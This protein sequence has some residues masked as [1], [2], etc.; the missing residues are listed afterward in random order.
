MTQIFNAEAQTGQDL[1]ISSAIEVHRVL[2]DSG[3]LDSPYA[4]CLNFHQ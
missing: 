4:M 3:L 1:I 2:G